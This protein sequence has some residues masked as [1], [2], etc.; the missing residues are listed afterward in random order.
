MWFPSVTASSQLAKN[1]YSA[2]TGSGGSSSPVQSNP[3]FGKEDVEWEGGAHMALSD[4]APTKLSS[5]TSAF[6]PLP[7]PS[8]TAMLH[9]T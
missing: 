3:C 1:L 5:L 8:A 7:W 4:L 6:L 2:F 9:S